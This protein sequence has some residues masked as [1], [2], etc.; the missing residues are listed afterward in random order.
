MATIRRRRNKYQVLVRKKTHKHISKTFH[1]LR[2]ARKW[3]NHME[4]R[5]NLGEKFYQLNKGITLKEVIH[6][7]LNEITPTKRGCES[8]TRRIR[9][10]LKE[11]ICKEKIYLLQT[12][13]FIGF[14]NKR[15]KDGNRTCHYDLVLLRHIYNVAIKQWN[16][17]NLNNPLINVPK[18]KLNPSRERRLTEA[19]YNFLVKGNY[20]QVTL[21]NIIELALETAMRRSEILNIKKEHINDRTLLIPVTKN[22]H[23][24]IIPLTKRA[25]Y[26]LENTLL[27]FPYTSNAL[28]LAWD[29]LKKKGNINNLT[30][31]DLRHEGLS[32][33]F[34]KGLSIPE[35]ALI[36]GHKDV[37]MLFRYTHLK[38]EDILRKI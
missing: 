24:R 9:R 28:R 6:R 27:P 19:E 5:I 1:D 10:L 31:H 7:Y 25:V 2:A 14:R 8:E 34:E 16:L 3:A 35:V 36:S 20:P 4:D 12:K 11:P 32:K 38:A 37:R 29:R 15:I 23:Q 30:F 17:F 18:P 21:R 22:D 33:L 26:L 13:D